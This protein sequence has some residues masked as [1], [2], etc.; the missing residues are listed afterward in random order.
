MQLQ[1]AG[2]GG[3]EEF[4]NPG[5]TVADGYRRWSH[6]TKSSTN[7]QIWTLS[8]SSDWWEPA[9]RAIL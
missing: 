8:Q 5:N 7:G 4:P 2:G 6:K 9:T 3:G 1:L